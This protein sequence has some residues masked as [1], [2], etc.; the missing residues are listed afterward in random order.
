MCFNQAFSSHASAR[1][2]PDPVQADHL[3]KHTED[4]W[5]MQDKHLSHPFVVQCFMVS[6]EVS[7]YDLSG[8]TGSWIRPLMHSENIMITGVG[9]SKIKYEV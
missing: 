9:V 7:T 3:R 2:A 5:K 1:P 8:F 4:P 6:R